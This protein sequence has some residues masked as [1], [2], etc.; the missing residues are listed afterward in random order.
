MRL[1]LLWVLWLRMSLLLLVGLVLWV[2]LV[3]WLLLR[4]CVL[5]R[6]GRLVGWEIKGLLLLLRL[7]LRWG[8]W[9]RLRLRLRV[10]VR[11]R[12][13]MW[14]RVQLLVLVVGRETR[15]VRGRCCA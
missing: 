3:G 14:V 7:W 10:R 11:M 13:R 6:D 8:V 5:L 12:M 4:G 9:R 1:Q 15:R 2:W